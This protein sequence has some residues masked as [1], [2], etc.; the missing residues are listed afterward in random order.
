MNHGDFAVQHTSL[1]NTFVSLKKQGFF[2][3]W[4]IPPADDE[5]REC[6]SVTLSGAY[7]EL[8]AR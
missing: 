1:S 6:D 5:G 3:E 8:T 2:R 7:P 4:T